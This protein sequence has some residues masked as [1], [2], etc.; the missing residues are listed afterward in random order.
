MAGFDGRPRPQP[1]PGDDAL[2][3]SLEPVALNLLDLTA[4]GARIAVRDPDRKTTEIHT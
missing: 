2:A 3:G 4:A 1:D